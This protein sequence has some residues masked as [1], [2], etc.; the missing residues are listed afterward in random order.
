[1]KVIIV[2]AGAAGLACAIQLKR[3][4]PTAEVTVLEHLAEPGKKL[5]ATGNGRCNATNKAAAGYA[6][7]KEF[8]ESVG[9][10]LRESHEGRIYPYANQA[11]SVVN[12]LLNACRQ[13]GITLLTDCHV[14]KAEKADGHFNVYTTKGGKTCD[15]LVLATGGQA[16]PSLGSD[17]SGYALAEAF[18]HTV[19]PLSPALVQLVSSS[20]HC[21]ALKGVRTKC[22]L[23][24]ETNGEIVADDSG[25]LLFTDYGLSGIVAMNL[26]QY[27]SD[28]RLKSG[29]DKSLAVIDFVP[30]MTEAQLAAHI[31][32]FGSLEGI[33]PAKLC[34]I[35]MKQANGDSAKTAQY[36]K[37]WRLIVTGTKGYNFAQITAGGVAVDSLS[38]SGESTLCE[39]LYIIGELTDRQFECG[40]FNLD[41]AFSGGVKA[42]N[43]IASK[44]TDTE[45]AEENNH[46]QN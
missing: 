9:L 21:R 4:L 39:A 11:A 33:L 37:R 27:V 32:H 28:A 6:V 18:G 14:Y 15:C 19:T 26:S 23:S 3:Q 1:M 17:G 36:A 45:A 35:M 31:A 8:L 22:R 10:V 13:Y 41:H 43:A 42:A 12:A 46:D 29:A 16:Q 38:E 34:Q 20:K 30:D 2:G 25:E 5:Y 40:G 44:H 24:I 7:T